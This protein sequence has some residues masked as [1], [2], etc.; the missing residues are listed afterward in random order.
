MADV[1]DLPVPGAVIGWIPVGSGTVGLFMVV[2]T[3]LTGLEVWER[4]GNEVAA[5]KGASGTGR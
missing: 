5:A 1:C 4:C 2:S 3:Y